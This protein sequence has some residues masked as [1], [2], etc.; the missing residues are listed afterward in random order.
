M[1]AEMRHTGPITD[2]EKS[3][4]IPSEASEELTQAMEAL[5]SEL[6]DIHS[7][8]DWTRLLGYSRAK[9]YTVIRTGYGVT[10]LTILTRKRYE[11]IVNLLQDDPGLTSSY[12]GLKVGLRSEQGVYKFLS[13]WYDT[14]FTELRMKMMSTDKNKTL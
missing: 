9:L 10:P 1:G 4:E 11:C 14:N 7:V 2:I 3:F 12:I 13:R 5:I 8:L 6:K